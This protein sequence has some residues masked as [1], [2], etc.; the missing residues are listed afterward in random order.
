MKVKVNDIHLNYEISGKEGAPAVVLSHSLACSLFMWEPQLKPLEEHFQVLRYDTRGH[1]LSDAPEGD[2]TI[3][4][5]GEDA[6]GLLDTLGIDK[7]H[8]VGLSMGGMIGQCLALNYAHRLMSLV[9]CDTGSV[10]PEEAQSVW[11]ERIDEARTG[12]ME[13]R[14]QATLENWF[15]PSY[16]KQEPPGLASIREQFLSTSVTGYIGCIQ[17]IR[18]LHFIDRLSE[19]KMPTLIIVGREDSGTPVEASEAMHVRIQGS[20]LVII[21]NAAHLSTVA[22]PGAV[23]SALLE[24]LRGL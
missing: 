19:I 22:Q 2:Y 15:T 23:N 14:L 1:G 18:G 4:Q 12:G 24:F 3:E 21:P 17:A 20:K 10:M 8:W 7:V 16:L 9:L 5:L 6:V 11:Q 13:A